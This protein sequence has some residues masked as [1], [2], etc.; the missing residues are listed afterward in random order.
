MS[1]QASYRICLIE[2]DAIM[3]EA[4]LDRFTIEGYVCDCHRT[5]RSALQALARKQYDVVICDIQ[6]PDI[7]G[8]DL[9]LQLGAGA[10]GTAAVCLHHRLRCR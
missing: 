7:N 3:G 10:N 6:L 2:D 8:E 9:F 1:T 4:L 5:G